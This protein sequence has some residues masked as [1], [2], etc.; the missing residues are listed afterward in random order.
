MKRPSKSQQISYI[1]YKYIYIT[2]IY[3]FRRR[4][5]NPSYQKNRN[6]REYDTKWQKF[7]IYFMI[8]RPRIYCAAFHKT[9]YYYY[10]FIIISFYWNCYGKFIGVQVKETDFYEITH[11]FQHWIE[12][13][14][15]RE[16]RKITKRKT[17]GS[18]I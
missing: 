16:E 9:D 7:P 18:D 14:K 12:T 5:R 15:K 6:Y 2:Y 17:N 1:F 4:W 11:S 13:K 10:D 3:C 8:L